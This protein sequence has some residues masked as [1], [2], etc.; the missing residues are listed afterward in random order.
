ML[1]IVR[2]VIKVDYESRNVSEQVVNVQSTH[3][4]LDERTFN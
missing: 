1:C 4:L 2:H 3:S